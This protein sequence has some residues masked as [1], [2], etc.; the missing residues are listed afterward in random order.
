M[1]NITRNNTEMQTIFIWLSGQGDLQGTPS[2]QDVMKMDIPLQ[3][4]LTIGNHQGGDF[5]AL[6]LVPTY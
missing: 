1:A 6:H 2:A 3:G 5:V 4:I